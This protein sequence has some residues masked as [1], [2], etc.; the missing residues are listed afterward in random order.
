MFNIKLKELRKS[1]NVTQKQVA[2]AIDLTERNYQDL[3]Y[4]VIKPSF[5]TLI[6]LCEYFQ[7]SGDY[8]L[9]LS[10]IKERR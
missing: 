5:N 1:H 3:E 4:G 6:K 9:G 10:E 7:V 8:L 2:V